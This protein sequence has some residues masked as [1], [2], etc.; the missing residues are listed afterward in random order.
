MHAFSCT[1]VEIADVRLIYTSTPFKRLVS[2]AGCLGL[3]ARGPPIS[4]K[5]WLVTWKV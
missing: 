2:L 4:Y 3:I 1:Y 5:K